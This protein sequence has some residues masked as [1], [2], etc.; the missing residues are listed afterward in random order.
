MDKEILQNKYLT[1]NKSVAEIAAQLKCSQHKVNY[2][3][4]KHGIPKRSISEAIYVKK[5]P[6]GDPFVPRPIKNLRDAQLQGIGIGLYWGEGTKASTHSVRLGNSDP[7]LLKIF[8]RFLIDLYGVDKKDFRFGLQIF[9][10]I[11]ER[12]ALEYWVNE[13][14]VKDSQFY[15]ITVT[16]SG[17][18]GTYRHKSK[19]GVVTVHYHNK[20]LR[21]AIIALLPR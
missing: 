18:L 15:K 17:S 14:G 2:W 11:N 5:H 1:E 9:T 10:D 21:D 8:M 13:L 4:A 20:K 3:L 12:E 16:I 6:L 19:Y 7:D